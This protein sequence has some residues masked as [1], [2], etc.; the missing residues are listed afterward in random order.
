LNGNPTE[1]FFEDLLPYLER[2][3]A[4]V[5]AVIQVLKEKGLTTDD[6][7]AK[8]VNSADVASEVRNRGLRVRMEYLFST[9][10]N[11]SKQ[12]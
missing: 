9:A 4:Q 5:G 10:E 11:R 7:F 1:K 6:D 12:A 3:D 2:L 8:K